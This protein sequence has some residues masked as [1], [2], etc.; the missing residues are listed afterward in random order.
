MRIS[1]DAAEGY[2]NLGTSGWHIDGAYKPMP[3]AFL[4]FNA[5]KAPAVGNTK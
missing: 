4:I 3:F 2:Q 1:N 5:I